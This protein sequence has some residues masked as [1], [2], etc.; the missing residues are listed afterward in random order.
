MSKT[1]YILGRREYYLLEI[2]KFKNKYKTEFI[3]TNNAKIE[4]AVNSL[5]QKL[6]NKWSEIFNG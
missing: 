3:E 1:S 2:C 5:N 4:V 6:F